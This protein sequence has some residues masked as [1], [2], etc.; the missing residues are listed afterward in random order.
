VS[1]NLSD[2]DKA[3]NEREQNRAN[4][5]FGIKHAYPRSW[6]DFSGQQAVDFGDKRP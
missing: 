6:G 2:A 4:E 3:K 5:V 1:Q